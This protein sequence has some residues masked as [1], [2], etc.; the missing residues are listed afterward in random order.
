MRSNGTALTPESSVGTQKNE[1]PLGPGFPVRAVTNTTF[2]TS[3]EGDARLLA[4]DDVVV[5]VLDRLGRRLPTSAP[6][7]GSV[8]ASDIISPLAIRGI[9]SCCNSGAIDDA[10]SP[11]WMA[12]VMM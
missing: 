1:M 5:A 4:R 6:P 8:K 2:E 10:I 7:L 11:R 3:A 12:L 9:H